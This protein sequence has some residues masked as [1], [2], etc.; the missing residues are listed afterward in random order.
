MNQDGAEKSYL[1][2]Y[3]R[4]ISVSFLSSLSLLFLTGE[5]FPPGLCSSFPFLSFFNTFPDLFSP[6][7]LSHPFQFLSSSFLSSLLLCSLKLF[8]FSCHSLLISSLSSLIPYSFHPLCF[9]LPSSPFLWIPFLQFLSTHFLTSD[10]LC[11]HEPSFPS[12]F[13]QFL[14]SPSRS[15]PFL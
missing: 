3:C 14:S 6:S 9:P 15:S 5:M 8:L 1:C 12:L 7:F 4:V 11:F 13:L 2:S 10:F